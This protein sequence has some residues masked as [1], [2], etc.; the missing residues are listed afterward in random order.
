ME[1]SSQFSR[2]VSCT[3]IC[4]TVYINRQAH[5]LSES[6]KDLWHNSSTGYSL[7]ASVWLC[8]HVCQYVDILDQ[9]PLTLVSVTLSLMFHH[10]G[11]K[12]WFLI[13]LLTAQFSYQAILHT[14]P[15]CLCLVLR[16]QAV[17][18]PPRFKWLQNGLLSINTDGLC[19]GCV[20]LMSICCFNQQIAGPMDRCRLK[21]APGI[22]TGSGLFVPVR[23]SLTLL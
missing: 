7:V 2:P 18:Q 6:E 11:Y 5:F 3:C 21:L 15:L 19:S 23:K 12:G 16:P 1:F 20:L 14:Y 9:F 22:C 13:W 10:P 8:V 17:H 4:L